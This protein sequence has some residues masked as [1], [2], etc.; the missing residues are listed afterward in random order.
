MEIEYVRVGELKPLDKNPRNITENQSE[1]L[2]KNIAKF[3]FVEPLVISQN[4]EIIGG[5]QRYKAVLDLSYEKVPCYRINL[6]NKKTLALMLALNKITG[7][8]DERKLTEVF[9]SLGEEFWEDTGFEDY[10][11]KEILSSS[12]LEKETD[13]NLPE[14]NEIYEIVLCFSN[15]EEY[16]QN[17]ELYAGTNVFEKTKH[18]IEAIQ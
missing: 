6:D 14:K 2:R 10:E 15:E 11:I 16:I 8:W 7:E 3:G 18:W 5:Y 17:L 12:I 4:N 1:K 13:F 9:D